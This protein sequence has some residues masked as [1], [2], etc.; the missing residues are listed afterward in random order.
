MMYIGEQPVSFN[1]WYWWMRNY[2]YIKGY[3]NFENIF[4]KEKVK[5]VAKRFLKR[6]GEVCFKRYFHEFILH[7]LETCNNVKICSDICPYRL[8]LPELPPQ[9]NALRID[10]A[11]YRIPKCGA[12]LIYDPHNGYPQHEYCSWKWENGEKWR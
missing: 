5:Q 3:D 7:E 8:P 12:K 11:G 4:S 9:R 10:F 1:G 6:F 2:A